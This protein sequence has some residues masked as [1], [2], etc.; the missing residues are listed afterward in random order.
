[1][2]ESIALDFWKQGFEV[3]LGTHFAAL[4]ANFP[5]DLR[6]LCQLCTDLASAG[7]RSADHVLACFEEMSIFA[8]QIDLVPSSHVAMKGDRWQLLTHRFPCG[9]MA[10]DFFIR[11]GTTGVSDGQLFKWQTAGYNGWRYLL[12]EIDR[13]NRQVSSGAKNV[14][15][16]TIAN[17]VAITKLLNALLRHSKMAIKSLGPSFS[18]SLFSLVE[19]FVH[20]SD[21]PFMLLAHCL[22][23]LSLVAAVDKPRLV[24]DRLAKTGLFPYFSRSTVNL[25]S[26]ASG[27][28]NPGL[29]GAL[30]AKQECVNGDYP[31]T[32]AFIDLL[33]NSSRNDESSSDV[34]PTTAS[35]VYVVQDIFP[36]FQQW[37]FANQG[38]KVRQSSSPDPIDIP[39]DST[40]VFSY[41]RY[42]D[43]RFCVCSTCCCRLPPRRKSCRC[44]CVAASCSRRLWP[45]WSA[46]WGPATGASSR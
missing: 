45:R 46:L 8:E 5:V 11:A 6:P 14:N 22:R 13:L 27:D 34:H 37:R 31:L 44:S 24:W 38:D 3:G 40:F 18:Q 30:L 7:P 42:S 41:R 32:S 1:V 36:S 21:P 39:T 23:A 16:D 19:K 17:V 20:M 26:A 2:Q 4:M 28:V 43:R 29:V 25:A 9:E 10:K 12:T 33:L 15:A 35:I